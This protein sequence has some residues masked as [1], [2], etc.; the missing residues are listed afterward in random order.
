MNRDRWW[1]WRDDVLA[2][3]PFRPSTWTRWQR[4]LM[5]RVGGFLL[6]VSTWAVSDRWLSERVDH[7][8]ARIRSVE[9]GSPPVRREVVPIIP[10]DIRWLADEADAMAVVA[11][12]LDGG[13]ADLLSLVSDAQDDDG[14]SLSLSA[15]GGYQAWLELIAGLYRQ[16]WLA[17][18]QIEL[19]REDDDGDAQIMGQLVLGWPLL[20]GSQSVSRRRGDVSVGLADAD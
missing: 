1:R 11:A 5:G 16:H 2:A 6:I 20:D 17:A 12:Q 3:Q 7:L 18:S 19:T 14:P 13:V 8:S 15:R 9:Q 10:E 4:R